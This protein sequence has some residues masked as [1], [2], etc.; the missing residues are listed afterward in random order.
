MQTVKKLREIF[1]RLQADPSDA[2]EVCSAIKDFKGYG[3]NLKNFSLIYFPVALIMSASSG[4]TG[5][6][7]SYNVSMGAPRKQHMSSETLN[8]LVQRDKIQADAWWNGNHFGRKLYDLMREDGRKLD[9]V[10]ITSNRCG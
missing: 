5:S 10:A 9:A 3:Y 7:Q 2:W 1:R 4:G 6:R 8:L